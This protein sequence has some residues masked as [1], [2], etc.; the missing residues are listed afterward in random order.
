MSPK[1][2]YIRIL[3]AVLNINTNMW[4]LPHWCSAR[5]LEMRL[6][7]HIFKQFQLW[8]SFITLTP[9]IVVCVRVGKHTQD[10]LKFIPSPL[11]G[12]SHLLWLSLMKKKWGKE[13]SFLSLVNSQSPIH[14]CFLLQRSI[15]SGLGMVVGLTQQP[16][17]LSII[18]ETRSGNARDGRGSFAAASQQRG[19][20]WVRVSTSGEQLAG[21]LC[22]EWDEAEAKQ[23]HLSARDLY[24][25]TH[26]A[27]GLK[28]FLG[29]YP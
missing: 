5:F 12:S 2:T 20:L 23:E 11:K 6:R 28:I 27:S 16:A 17:A 15:F 26:N 13:S 4:I 29:L 25:W 1:G 7:I 3:P 9:R 18:P 21:W 22:D 24:V 14:I 19:H 10:S 8:H